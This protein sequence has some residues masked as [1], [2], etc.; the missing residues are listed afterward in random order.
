MDAALPICHFAGMLLSRKL[1]GRLMSARDPGSLKEEGR[2]GFLLKVACLLRKSRC[3]TFACAAT[4]NR[5]PCIK[6]V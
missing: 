2:T 5:F 1:F 4:P 6:A 3:S